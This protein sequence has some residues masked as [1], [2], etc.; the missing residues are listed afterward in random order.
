MKKI[1]FVTTIVI[2][3]PFLI[4]TFFTKDEIVNVVNNVKNNISLIT[5]EDVRVKRSKLDRIDTIPFE[6]YIVGVVAGEMPVSFN[7]EA[8][9]AQAIAARNYAAKKILAN[10]NQ[11]YDLIDTTDNQVY[12]DIQQLKEKWNENYSENINKIRE[13]VSETK[14]EYLT[15]NDEIIDLFY[16]S[17]SNGKT[18][19]VQNVFNSDA[20]YLKSVESPW[21]ENESSTFKSEKKFSLKEF[22]SLLNIPFNE[23]LEITDIEKTNSNRVSKL[24]INNQ[25]FT[26]RQIYQ[27]LKIRSTDFEI[28]QDNEDVIIKTVG[29]GHG[30]GMSQYGANGMAKE[31]YTYKD[32]LTH[33][34]QGTSI[35]KIKNFKNS[36]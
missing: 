22:Y 16:F 18:E 31:G 2:L 34:F 21:D 15:Y 17:T 8:L 1:I 27:L 4:V 14:A 24:K 36:V 5:T 6:E 33:Y 35:K 13:A 3:I 28:I 32:I 19:D 26:G 10:T 30:V 29:Y 23:K 9:K 11:E 7:S 20:P 25:E 12:Y